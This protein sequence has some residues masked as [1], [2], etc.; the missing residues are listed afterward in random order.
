MQ[1]G[2]TIFLGLGASTS[3]DTTKPYRWAK[4]FLSITCFCLG[5][6][7]FSLS[8]RLLSPLRRTTLAASFL[9]QTLIILVTAGVVQAGVVD[10]SLHTIPDD[11]D[12]VQLLPIALLSFQ[13]AGQIVASRSL[14]L[15]EIPT[16]VVTSMM[17]DI[18]S[19]RAV[20]SPVRK[21]VKR[22]R[23]TLAFFGILVGAVAGGFIAEKTGR[24]QV[25]LWIAGGIK[26]CISG[27]WVVWPAKK[28]DV[29]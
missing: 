13:S 14:G 20:L 24:M 27:A 9:L 23:R 7:V 16:V 2:N 10:G 21:N 25:P 28:H 11:I 8:S 22:N 6:L 1:Q 3:H 5:C 26:L 4:S 19:D 29:V 17:H 15:A 12:W 18:A